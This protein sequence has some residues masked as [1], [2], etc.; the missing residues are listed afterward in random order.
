MKYFALYFYQ[1]SYYASLGVGSKILKID[2][3]MVNACR[4]YFLHH[5]LIYII[6]LT[7]PSCSSAVHAYVLVISPSVHERGRGREGMLEVEGE[8]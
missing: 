6:I 4:E 1:L 2:N 8:Q 5:Y 3:R 7:L